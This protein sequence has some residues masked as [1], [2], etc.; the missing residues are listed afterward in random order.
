LISAARTPAELTGMVDRRVL[1]E[2]L[3]QVLGWAEFCGLRIVVEPG[4]FVP[5]RRSELLAHL[6]SDAAR[7]APAER[8]VV[9][10]LCCGTGAVGAAVADAV[11]RVDVHAADVDHAAVQCARQNLPPQQVYEGDLFDALPDWL[12]GRID[13]L[14]ANAPYVPTDAIPLMR[15]EARLHEALVAL[16]GGADGLDVQHR[17]AAGALA[18]LAPEGHL[19]I[20]TSAAQ[21][22]TTMEIFASSGLQPTVASSTEL[23]ATVV[24]GVRWPG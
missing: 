18:W 10:D 2:P 4:V 24:A 7:E 6:A 15:A 17:I 1:G 19:L 22:E 20:E 3:E 14:V 5:R 11:Q 13:V 8:P 12:R 16:D 21:A 9:V 23:D